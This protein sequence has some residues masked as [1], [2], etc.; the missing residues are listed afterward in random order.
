MADKPQV[1]QIGSQLSVTFNLFD[2][3]IV[4][5]D[6]AYVS[7]Y[8][9]MLDTDETVGAAFYFLTLCVL[10]YLGEYSHPDERITGFVREC[11]EEM[12]GSLLLAC[13]D[14]LSAVWAGYSVTEIVWRPAAARIKLDYLATYHP[15]TISFKVNR[16]G[17]LEVIEQ[18]STYQA[19][20]QSLP[21]EKCIVFSYRKRFGNYY[22]KSAFKPVRKNWLLKDALLKMWAKALDKFGTPLMVAI[23]PD[24]NIVDPETKEEISQLEY[25]TKLL[26]NLQH[27]TA[28]ALSAGGAQGPGASSGSIQIPDVKALVTGGSGVGSAFNLAINYL[29]K[30]ICRGLLVPSLL[31]DE[32]ARSGSLALGTSHFY[33]FLLMVKAI[34]RQLKEVLLDQLIARLV[35]YN[36]GP[37]KDYGDFTETPPGPE[38]LE[39]WSKIF[40]SLVNNGLMDVETDEDFQFAR[41]KMGLPQRPLS[42]GGAQAP[43]ETV[44]SQ[45]D[46]YFR[47]R[48]EE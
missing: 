20:E 25:A 39:T 6:A 24:G 11:F 3:A 23:V 1:G 26:N 38:E 16:F 40:D 9:R 48:Q 36:F 7:E 5:P 44:A 10:S 4:N 2:G 35:D 42:R 27:G 22:G 31:F 37:Q 19:M 47:A 32:G 12:D 8:E 28:L 34:F 15:S 21:L 45:Y 41:K 30:M 43:V 46:R 17:R 18:K 14:I 29:N 33:S 13:E